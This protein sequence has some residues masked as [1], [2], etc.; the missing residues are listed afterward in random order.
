MM[1]SK[2]AHERK[3]VL[4]HT[5]PQV[6]YTTGVCLR[7]LEDLWVTCFPEDGNGFAATFLRDYF[8]PEQGIC[9][10][11]DGDVQSALYMLPCTY[12]VGDKT[13]S[14]VYIYAMCTHPDHRRKG[15]LRRMLEF[16]EQHCK[17]NGIDGLVL[18]AL[19]TSKRVVE[20]FGMKPLLTWKFRALE[21]PVQSGGIVCGGDFETFYCLRTQ[22]LNTLPAVIAWPRRELQ[23]IYEDLCRGERIAFFQETDGALCYQAI[24]ETDSPKRTVRSQNQQY[25]AHIKMMS[26]QLTEDEQASL[27]FNLLLQ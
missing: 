18:H 3:F 24:D 14:L 7:A 2:K 8:R 11:Q 1:A 16:A 13:G 9:I 21:L 20:A 19:D 23:F 22:Y 6:Q 10:A 27:Y 25:C 4:E 12:R 5:A 15:N 17:Q 26:E